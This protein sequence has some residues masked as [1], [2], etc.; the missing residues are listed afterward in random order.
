MTQFCNYMYSY[1]K[2]SQINF[3]H[4]GKII[5]ENSFHATESSNKILCLKTAESSLKTISKANFKVLIRPSLKSQH[6]RE[7]EIF[8]IFSTQAI[9]WKILKCVFQSFLFMRSNCSHS[10]H[11][12]TCAFKRQ[13]F[14]PFHSSY[15]HHFI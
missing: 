15:H 14:L 9:L 6:H 8:I 12:Y 10:C 3:S 1:W 4:L 13:F 5:C 11:A 2:F 7:H